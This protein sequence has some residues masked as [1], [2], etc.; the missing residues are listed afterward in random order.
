MLRQPLYFKLDCGITDVLFIPRMQFFCSTPLLYAARKG[1]LPTIQFLVES[2][3]KVNQQND[4]GNTALHMVT[5]FRVGFL[6]PI[7]AGK[8]ST[9]NLSPESQPFT[10]K[11]YKRIQI[12]YN[13]L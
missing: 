12:N 4:E 5:L 11:T 10:V 13:L 9:L 6:G 1:H 3:A 2:G 7:N 8:D